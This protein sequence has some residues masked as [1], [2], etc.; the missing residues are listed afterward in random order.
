[1][2]HEPLLAIWGS[3]CRLG[4]A[5]SQQVRDIVLDLNELGQQNAQAQLRQHGELVGQQRQS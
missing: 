5:I 2:N 1:M 4:A 3:I